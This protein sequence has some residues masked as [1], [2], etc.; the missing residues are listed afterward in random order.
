MKKKLFTL[1]IMPALLTG[2][3]STIP[4]EYVPF[5]SYIEKRDMMVEYEDEHFYRL[6][7]TKE[8]T[9]RDGTINDVHDLLALNKT[10]KVKTAIPSTGER[11]L[12]VVPVYF[13]DSNVNTLDVKHL[14]LENAFFGET[15]HTEYDSVAGYYNKTSYGQLRLTGEV[16]PWV[17]IGINSNDWKSL[18]SS[19][20]TASAIIAARAVDYLKE[21]NLIDFSLYDTDEDDNIDGVYVIYDHPFDQRNT[22]DSLYWAFTY[23]TYEGE[24]GLNKEAPY[25]NDFAWTSVN[26]ITDVGVVNDNKS[27]TNYLIHETGHLL[28]LSDYYNVYYTGR[29]NF[30]YQPTGSFDM[31]DYNI[32]DHSAFSKYLLKWTSPLVLKHGTSF[33]YKLKPLQSSGEYILV[34][35]SKYK[36]S[37]YGEYLLLE[38]FTPQGLNKYSEQFEYVTGSGAK[39]IYRYP[40]YFG[41]KI[42]HVNASLGYY[43]QGGGRSSAIAALDDPDALAKIGQDKV[44]IDYLYD[45]SIT[46]QQALNGQPVL[47]H[48]LES[49]GE[50]TFKDAMPASNKTL[51]TAGSDFGINTFI[52]FKFSNGENPNF[53]LKVKSI[54]SIDITLEIS[55][56]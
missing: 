37:P 34:P 4:L 26:A 8:V 29:N 9:H 44:A 43:K 33:T 50:N 16:A 39:I 30:H 15:N 55:F 35:S 19:H 14:Y 41:L 52:D 48:L 40:Q 1:L 54:S 38:Y 31:M 24:N 21:H 36:D 3:S 28:G 5:N 22:S 25:L 32:G 6:K 51:F 27:Y 20:S 53:K 13:N 45:N 11:K 18:S 42:F 2:C 10:G 49:S 46:D 47:Y 56:E 17:N 23:Y 7:N 12:L